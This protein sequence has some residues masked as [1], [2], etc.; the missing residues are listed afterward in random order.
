MVTLRDGSQLVGRVI[1][2]NTE[3]IA[4]AANPYDFSQLTKRPTDEVAEVAPSQVSLMPLGTV[5]LMNADELKDLM[6]Y[7]I[8]GGDARH[9]VFRAN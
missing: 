1:Y 4:V 7:L 6:A 3:E 5:A 9:R 8:S 2:R